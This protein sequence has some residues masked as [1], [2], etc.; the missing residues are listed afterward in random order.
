MPLTETLAVTCKVAEIFEQIGAPCVIGGSVA[1]SLHGIPRAT[2]DVDIV[3]NLAPPHV[4]ALL[5]CL[6]GRFYVDEGAIRDAIRRSSSFNIIHLES[7]LKIDVFICGDDALKQEE[8]SRARRITVDPASGDTLL[9][10][11]AT[12]IILQKL[13]WYELGNRV[14]ERQ[15]RDVIGV[16]KVSGDRLDMQYLHRWAMNKNLGSLVEQAFAEAGRSLGEM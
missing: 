15:W 10:A 1:S 6:E 2:Q 4:Q 12:D 11:D 16:I 14:S 7:M 9:V 13:I 5:S 3:V 8:L